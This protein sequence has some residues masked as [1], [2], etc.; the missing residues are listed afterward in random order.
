MGVKRRALKIGTRRKLKGGH[1]KA[2]TKRRA[3]K[4]LVTKVQAVKG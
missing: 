2:G 1:E 3:L 4:G